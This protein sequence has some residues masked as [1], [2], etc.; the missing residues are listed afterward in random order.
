MF[1]RDLRQEL[2]TLPAQ[3]PVLAAQL[4]EKLAASRDTAQGRRKNCHPISFNVGDSALLWDQETHRYVEPVVVQ[5]PNP[6]LDGQVIYIGSWGK[7]VARS[8]STVVG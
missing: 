8:W 5:A 4:P 6:G 2:P 1:G 7:M 3:E